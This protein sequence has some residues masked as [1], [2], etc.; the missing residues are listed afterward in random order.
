MKKFLSTVLVALVTFST[1][2]FAGTPIDKSELPQPSMDFI[3]KYFSNVQIKKVEKDNGRRGAEYE[4]DF[5]NGA[6]VDFIADGTWKEIKM[7]KGEAVPTDLV[8]AE[9]S[10]YVATNHSGQLIVEISRLRG[11]Y[12]IELSNGKELKLTESA[13]P[14][15]SRKREGRGNR[16]GN[17][18]RRM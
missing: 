8:P 9:I 2:V 13:E 1:T 4:V 6:E 18:P 14:M 7:A 15:Q 16:G 12:E 17:R 10:K 5:T 3:A 11:G